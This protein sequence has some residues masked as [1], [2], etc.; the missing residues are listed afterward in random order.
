MWDRRC[1]F[2]RDRVYRRSPI[3][4][5]QAPSGDCAGM[6]ANDW[7]CPSDF[8]NA[9]KNEVNGSLAFVICGFGIVSPNSDR[10]DGNQKHSEDYD[11][12]A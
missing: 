7:V 4:A 2:C 9:E 12:P 10:R 3:P 5:H 6:L 11:D 1:P 8:R